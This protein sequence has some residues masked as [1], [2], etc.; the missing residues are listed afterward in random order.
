[1]DD[2]Q[3][4]FL[5]F[6]AINEFM[7]SDYRQIVIQNVLSSYDRLPGERRSAL[8]SIIKKR[9][10]V[11]GFRN[12]VQAPALVKAR[13]SVSVFERRP[14]YVAQILQ[15][16][17]ELRPELRQKVYD[18][19][20]GREWDLL[21]PEADRTRLPGFMIVWPEGETYDV[22][23]EAYNQAYPD[24]EVQENDLRLMIVWLANRLP[25]DM[26][27]DEAAPEQAAGEQ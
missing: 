1:M 14:E 18:F 16:W 13:A 8:N 24:D 4:Q 7:L 19:L 21:P 26:D 22:L 25:Y 15:G 3:V 2:K 27:E 17:S 5:P 23:G 9:V 12:S 20:K 10:Q 6:N 11:P